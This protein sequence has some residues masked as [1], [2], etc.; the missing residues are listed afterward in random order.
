MAEDIGPPPSDTPGQPPKNVYNH[1]PVG[2]PP[3]T[4]KPPL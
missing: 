2:K 4:P 1:P 3:E